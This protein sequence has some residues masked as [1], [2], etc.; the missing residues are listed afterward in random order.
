MTKTTHEANRI[1]ANT[2][3][4][5]AKNKDH[6]ASMRAEVGIVATSAEVIGSNNNLVFW[7][8]T[9][10]DA[11]LVDLTEFA[12]GGASDHFRW[13]G[14]FTG[15]PHLIEELAPAI[16]RKLQFASSDT[17]VSNI[18]HFRKWW[19]LF[20]QI[21][22][23]NSKNNLALK[24]SS[25]QRIKTVADLGP[26]HGNSA[27]Q[28]GMSR[29]EFSSFV[30]AAE[31]TRKVL[32]LRQ[33]SWTTPDDPD[34]PVSTLAPDEDI[35]ALYHGIKRDWHAATDH[36][37]LTDKLIAGPTGGGHLAGESND[38]IHLRAEILRVK[39]KGSPTPSSAQQ[40]LKQRVEYEKMLL[41]NIDLWANVTTRLDKV[42]LNAT[43]LHRA[44]N[45]KWFDREGYSIASM[46]SALYPGPTDARAAFHLCMAVG[47]LNPSVLTG[48]QIDLPDNNSLPPN[49][50]GPDADPLVR[51]A[52]ILAICPFLQQSPIDTEYAIEGWKNRSKSFIERTYQWKQHLTPGPILVEMIIRSWP[53][54]LSLI[55]DLREAQ[56]HLN[57]GVELKSDNNSVDRL[58]KR[59]H[60]LEFAVRSPWLYMTYNQGIGWLHD[61]NF[62]TS[63]PTIYL[64][65]VS[66]RINKIR[67]VQGRCDLVRMRSTDFR[68]AYA[69]WALDHSGGDVLAVMVA[70]DHRRFSTTNAYL[71]NTVIHRRVLKKQQ[72]FNRALISSFREGEIDPTVLA[73][74][75]RDSSL[76]SEEEAI[77]NARLKEYRRSSKS[78]YQ[79]GCRDPYH[80]DP[81]VDPTFV[82]DGSR[83]CPKHRCTLC[84]ANAI[85]TPASYPG[86]LLRQAELEVLQERMP[87]AA[88]L[89][90]DYEAELM[91][92]RVALRPYVLAEPEKAAAM[93]AN[94]KDEI[95]TG[96]RRT[97]EMSSHAD[98]EVIWASVEVAM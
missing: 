62:N 21:E 82:A 63:G 75:A 66:N 44:R 93:L 31:I 77:M 28:A 65:Q 83:V 38:C 35:K 40:H 1:K 85:I 9:V 70:L 18:K 59:V 98:R 50:T 49:L 67:A 55:K 52:W 73:M 91:N 11:C 19:R 33:L 84:H 43:D 76:C 71:H 3:P 80:P 22:A 57:T 13:G 27:V 72:D 68:D 53:L 24:D 92:T 32:G 10:G 29:N 4:R 56:D 7:T 96:K 6:L 47:G 48:L 20:D 54:R 61:K 25:S 89:L 39:N 74:R 17:C 86:L 12:S 8:T 37:E 51:R 81:L 30:S 42:Q 87:I 16:R 94:Y 95:R 88:F 14:D 26:I 58:R 34:R 46:V 78:R 97:P 15:R 60:S 64:D 45:R 79:V 5:I 90:S 2:P 69:V 23:T 41:K 36:W